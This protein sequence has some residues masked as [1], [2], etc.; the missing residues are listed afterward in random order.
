MQP[1]FHF[2]NSKIL[3]SLIQFYISDR[4]REFALLDDVIV[5]HFKE[6]PVHF[7]HGGEQVTAYQHTQDINSDNQ[8][9]KVY[10]V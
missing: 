1:Q 2:K 5:H 3:R 4:C 7:L 8:K 9:A 6:F 10:L